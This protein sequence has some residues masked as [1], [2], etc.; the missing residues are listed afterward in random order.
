MTF[1]RRE[2]PNDDETHQDESSSNSDDAETNTDENDF[3]FLV[4]DAMALVQNV[5]ETVSIMQ[6]T[7]NVQHA[8]TD[9]WLGQLDANDCDIVLEKYW[10]LYFA[11][12]NRTHLL[13]GDSLG[14]F[15]S[16]EKSTYRNIFLRNPSDTIHAFQNNDADICPA[17]TLFLPSYWDF[18]LESFFAGTKLPSTF[19]KCR[20]YGFLKEIGDYYPGPIR[21]AW[22]DRFTEFV[23]LTMRSG[24]S[25][26]KEYNWYHIP[27][28]LRIIGTRHD[29]ICE[30]QN[31][32]KLLYF[33]TS[34]R[35]LPQRIVFLPHGKYDLKDYNGGDLRI[36]TVSKIVSF[37]YKK[38]TCLIL[39]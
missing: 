24:L 4:E 18:L 34:L 33:Q 30:A 27:P 5:V 10:E 7:E 13:T 6:N 28:M 39:F 22:P 21:D 11:N 20:F 16:N 19:V 8:S 29:T 23:K 25:S 15:L 32:F 31:D 17:G 12:Q 9:W 37:M 1:S 2:T 26:V 3:E 35:G 36:D 14:Q 38:S